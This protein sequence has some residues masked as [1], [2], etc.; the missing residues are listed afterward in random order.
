V[1]SHNLAR[2][3]AEQSSCFV[4]A[5]AVDAAAV[6]HEPKELAPA[7][8]WVVSPKLGLEVAHEDAP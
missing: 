4:T 8:M 2:P 1:A 5:R 7:G 6:V 3:I